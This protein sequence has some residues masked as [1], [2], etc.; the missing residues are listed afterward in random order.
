MKIQIYNKGKIEELYNFISNELSKKGAFIY[1]TPPARKI[2]ENSPEPT[3]LFC[4]LQ[5]I[6]DPEN[7][8]LE[9]ITLNFDKKGLLFKRTDFSMDFDKEKEISLDK[10]ER[11]LFQFATILMKYCDQKDYKFKVK[12]RRR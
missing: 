8:T 4:Y 7:P 1:L 12:G 6:D 5:R 3:G 10:R 9:G 2:S 11:H